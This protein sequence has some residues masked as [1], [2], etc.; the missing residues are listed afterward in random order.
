MRS[1]QDNLLSILLHQSDMQA[2]I[3]DLPC[4]LQSTVLQLKPWSRGPGLSPA[5][6]WTQHA[7]D[8][9]N[10]SMCL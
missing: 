10:I 4:A 1:N 9:N 8:M 3:L 6:L 2:D 7:I 5:V